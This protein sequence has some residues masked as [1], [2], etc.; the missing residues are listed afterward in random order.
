[1]LWGRH[2]QSLVWLPHSASWQCSRS[3]TWHLSVPTHLC[4][5]SG[6]QAR[7]FPQSGSHSQDRQP[8]LSRMT[9]VN[10]SP[11]TISDRLHITTL[12]DGSRFFVHP[13][14]PSFETGVHLS[15]S[16]F[17]KGL[18]DIT[19]HFQILYS[20]TWPFCVVQA[21]LAG[22]VDGEWLYRRCLVYT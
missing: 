21:Y 20:Y 15:A 9:L 13:L 19:D 22:R 4:R 12:R 5:L 11:G 17:M 18:L 7:Y 14:R 2:S 3:Q 16:F 8:F 6:S 1:M 10:R